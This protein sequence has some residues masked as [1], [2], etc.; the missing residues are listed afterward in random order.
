VVIVVTM[1]MMVFVVTMVMMVFVVTMVCRM[2]LTSRRTV[3]NE[4]KSIR[5]GPTRHL[6]QDVPLHDLKV[7]KQETLVKLTERVRRLVGVTERP[8]ACIQ[9]SDEVNDMSFERGQQTFDSTRL[10]DP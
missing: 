8:Y 5:I 3:S 4:S 6:S 7:L 9:L 2:N 10:H 1:V